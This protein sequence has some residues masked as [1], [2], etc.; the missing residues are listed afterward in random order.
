MNVFAY[1]YEVIMDL[2]INEPGN[3]KNAVDSINDN[4]NGQTLFE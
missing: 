3:G 4:D 1:L 2:S